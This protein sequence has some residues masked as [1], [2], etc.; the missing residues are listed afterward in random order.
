MLAQRSQGHSDSFRLLFF[1]GTLLAA[2]TMETLGQNQVV[3]WFLF[4][5][6]MFSCGM[7]LVSKQIAG[8][9]DK[10]KWVANAP[11]AAS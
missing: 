1:A 8:K 4:N 2:Q 7:A 3:E 10:M 9:H 5:V 11:K 6:L